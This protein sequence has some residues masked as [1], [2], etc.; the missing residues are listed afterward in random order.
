MPRLERQS[1]FSFH[2]RD[3]MTRH[4]LESESIFD[5]SQCV[6]DALDAKESIEK[7]FPGKNYLSIAMEYVE[8]KH[9]EAIAEF[10]CEKVH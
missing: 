8:K 1:V 4:N 6:I 3:K 7:Y 9:L 5:C 2:R 10:A